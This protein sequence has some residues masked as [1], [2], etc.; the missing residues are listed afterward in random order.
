MVMLIIALLTLICS[1]VL[2]TGSLINTLISGNIKICLSY[3]FLFIIYI[4]K[5]NGIDN[6]IFYKIQAYM[7]IA[8][9]GLFNASNHFV[10]SLEIIS[11]FNAFILIY[12][13]RFKM[14]QV[15]PVI[16]SI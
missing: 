9:L 3:S 5:T 7:A 8:V 2:L 16:Q 10:L 11:L 4:L 15:L 12:Y 14:T 6:A 13:H 1:V